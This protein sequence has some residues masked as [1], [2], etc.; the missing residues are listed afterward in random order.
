VREEVALMTDLS[1]IRRSVVVPLDPRAA[2]DL[3]VFRIS[4]WWPLATRSV[5]LGN[6]VSLHFEPRVGGRFFERGRDGR[7]EPW[8]TV[9]AWE[10]PTR[11]AFTWHPGMADTMATEVEVRFTGS[12]RE[13]LVEVVHRNWERMGERAALVRGLYDGSAGWPGVL[14]R[15]VQRAAGDG[16][17]APVTGPGCGEEQRRSP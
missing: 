10:E 2:F 6:A 12:T 15:F 17:L 4:E 13:T 14:E 5:L 1:P 16:Q 9:L 8:G 7:E 3:F 11:V